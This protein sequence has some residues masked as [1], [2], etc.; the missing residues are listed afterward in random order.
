MSRRPVFSP[1]PHRRHAGMTLIE[2]MIAML[3]GLLVIGG[4]LGVFLGSSETSRRTDDLARIQENARIAL[5]LMSRSLREAGGNACGVPPAQISLAGLS[6]SNWWTGGANFEGAFKG[7]GSTDSLPPAAKGSIG[8]PTAS[9]D[10]FIA[11][12][13]SAGASAVTNV[14]PLTVKSYQGLTANGPQPILFGCNHTGVGIIFKPSAAITGNTIIISSSYS[15]PAIRIVSRVNA[16][17]WFVGLNPRGGAS[18]YRNTELLKE[19]E[20]V[21]PDVASMTLSYLLPEADNYVSAASIPSGQWPNVIAVQIELKLERNAGITPG[22][23]KISRTFTQT[24]TL[25]NRSAL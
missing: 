24:V 5:D 4:V 8:S 17:A 18:L 14:S 25:R 21:A 13:A 22:S 23:G 7:Y 10:A 16:E 3:L 2:L 6:S 9:S 11:I 12:S 15:L 20:E 1:A 19:P